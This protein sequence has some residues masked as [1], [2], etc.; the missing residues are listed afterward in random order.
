MKLSPK[1]HSTFLDV[2][3]VAIVDRVLRWEYNVWDTQLTTSSY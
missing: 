1:F 3:Q 2:A